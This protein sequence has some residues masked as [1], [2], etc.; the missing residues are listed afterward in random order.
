MTLTTVQFARAAAA[1]W[2]EHVG[3]AA[4]ESIRGGGFEIKAHIRVRHPGRIRVEYL[5]Y[6]NPLLELEEEL[7]GGAEF[8]GEELTGLSMIHNGH[9]T[10]IVDA[11]SSLC[12]RKSRRAVYEP[13]VGFDTI[14]ELGF[15]D[16]WTRDYLMKDL[17]TETIAGQEARTL[18]IKP[19]QPARSHF[20]SVVSCPIR[21]A[22]ISFDQETLFP[23]RIRFS[24][25]PDMPLA[26]LLPPGETIT[27]EYS[28]VRLQAPGSDLFEH[29]PQDDDRIFVEA[30]IS[31]DA[32]HD[33]L[34]FPFDPDRLSQA[35][36]P[37]GDGQAYAT[38][39]HD[40]ERGYAVIPLATEPTSEGRRRS[41][42]LLV[43]NFLSRNMARRRM[44]LAEKGEPLLPG[45]AE[46]QILDR[47]AAW[48]EQFG[49]MAPAPFFEVLWESDG[50]YSFL[51]TEGFERDDVVKIAEHLIVG[52]AAE[53]E[54]EAA[55]STEED[56]SD[57]AAPE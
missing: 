29:A 41:A 3:F 1:A 12:I 34:P 43:G 55:A 30:A 16:T 56:T 32:L 33:G 22:E 49:Q 44:A 46:A 27:V 57:E 10:W 37:P 5:T 31:S 7:G 28:D 47:R 6:Q 19:K 35:G 18:R 52:A 38:I 39:D 13:L 26:Q 8:T 40:N 51:V 48:S 14:G 2:R 36:Y 20:L 53:V 25:S 11:K 54:P 45:G 17:G 21:F 50:V 24:P 15:L 42:T 4:T 23:V 9:E